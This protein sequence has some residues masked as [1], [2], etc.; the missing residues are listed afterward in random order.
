M[1]FLAAPGACRALLWGTI[2]VQKQWCNEGIQIIDLTLITPRAKLCAEL[3]HESLGLVC[4]PSIGY[5]RPTVS[6]TAEYVVAE[7]LGL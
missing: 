3:E 5:V 4:G 6:D 1:S 7:L 2:H